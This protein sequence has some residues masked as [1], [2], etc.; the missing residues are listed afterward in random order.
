MQKKTLIVS[1]KV[2]AGIGIGFSFFLL[3][4]HPKSN[5]HKKLPTKN[6]KNFSLVP[7]ITYQKNGITYHFHH[8]AIITLCYIPFA[9]TRK[10][11][12][13][14]ILHGIFLGSIL[15]G[16]LYKDRFIF[17]YKNDERYRQV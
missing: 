2:L 7:H 14:Y 10:F 17:H 13:Q 6:Y 4:S 16:L 11:R 8:W 3:T 5:V 1:G 15:Q 9:Y 12:K